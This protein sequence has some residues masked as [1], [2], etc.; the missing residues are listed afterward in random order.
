MGADRRMKRAFL[1]ALILTGAGAFAAEPSCTANLAVLPVHPTPNR[2]QVI[3]Q[4]FINEAGPFNFLLDTGS[5]VTMVDESLAAELHLQ[6]TAKASVVGVSLQG[7]GGKYALV[8]SVR[9][10]ESAK[11]GSLYVLAFDMKEMHAAGFKVRGL[12]GEDFLSHFDATIDN[13]HNRVCL[14]GV[15]D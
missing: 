8:N 12:I 14:T 1:V 4:A 6:P 5:Q 2:N 11:V 10:G 3:L 13:T 7:K 9:V 15:T